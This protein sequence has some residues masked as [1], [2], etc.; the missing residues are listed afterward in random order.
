MFY[1]L[2]YLQKAKDNLYQIH[3]FGVV[4]TIKGIWVNWR[5]KHLDVTPD[6]H[7]YQLTKYGNYF[8]EASLLDKN[9]I[10]YSCGVGQ[11][12]SFDLAISDALKCK[13]FLFD[14]TPIAADYMKQFEDKLLLNYQMVGVWSCD[15]IVKFFVD[16]NP[17][18]PNGKNFSITNLSET[19]NYFEAKV[20]SVKSIM[21]L[22]E[23]DQID[24]L[25]MDIEGAA[26]EVLKH[27]IEQNILPKQIIV[28]FEK[29]NV[30]AGASIARVKEYYLE[31][32][33][34]ILKL[35]NLNYV[36]TRYQ[37]DEATFVRVID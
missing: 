29:P 12:I 17:K 36:L 19:E 24:V 10:I 3:Y 1:W 32:E 28:E 8:V 20:I 33:N 27:I 2:V 5:H 18:H 6:Q 37:R 22:L 21:K 16:D 14:P 15:K 35:R 25:K 9:S 7:E 31:R 11:D 4:N 30:R 26:I 13:V 23:H 34:I